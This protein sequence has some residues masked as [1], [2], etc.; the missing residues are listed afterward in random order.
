MSELSPEDAHQLLVVRGML[1]EA[2]RYGAKA[3]NLQR[4]TA[5]VVLDGVVERVTHLVAVTRGLKI[6][7]NDG[8]DEIVSKVKED[9]GQTWKARGLAEVR[10]LHRARNSA[11]HE[12]LGP[13]RQDIPNWSRGTTSYVRSLVD[14]QFNVDIEH[15]ALTDVVDDAELRAGLE[16]AAANLAGG[17]FSECV[18]RCGEVVESARRRWTSLHTPAAWAA[19]RHKRLFSKDPIDGVKAYIETIED[20]V[21]LATFA[22]DA[23]E[24]AWFLRIGKEPADLLGPDDADRALAFATN[25]VLG[26]EEAATTWIPDR[27]AR[28]ERAQRL[29]RSDPESMSRVC[30]IV[31]VQLEGSTSLQVAVRIENVPQESLFDEWK[32]LVQHELWRIYDRAAKWGV[33]RDGTASILLGLGG[34]LK[35]HVERLDRALLEADQTLTTRISGAIEGARTRLVGVATFEEGLAGWSDRPEWLRSARLD[36]DNFFT[37]LELDP[38]VHGATVDGSSGLDE[39]RKLFRGDAR[40]E[41]C[42]SGRDEGSLHILPAIDVQTLIAV[43]SDIDEQVTRVL[44]EVTAGWV[45]AVGAVER[46][47]AQG[48]ALFGHWE[49]TRDIAAGN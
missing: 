36:L 5:L 28:Y 7:R 39:I 21:S 43:V 8:L 45:T 2:V 4:V 22:P 6:G 19:I 32:D 29:V 31:D 35:E 46:I 17:E 34:D 41:N 15:L 25:W 37:E 11:Q 10:Q 44:S 23:A 47:R 30:G 1:D 38:A 48:E 14:A 26:F 20:T 40:I 18:S 3:T 12:G 49:P 9:L 27:L 13:D 33:R 24:A 42:R 16:E